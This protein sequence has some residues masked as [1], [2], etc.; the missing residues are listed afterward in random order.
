MKITYDIDVQESN[1][2]YIKVAEEAL[3]GLHEASIPGAFLVDL[4]P[5]LKFVPSWFPGAG[6][7]IKAAHCREVNKAMIENPFRYVKEQLVG[8]YYF[9]REISSLIE[10]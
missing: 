6:F 9:F 8:N 3:K 4:F 2:P 10:R 7:Q 5:M 1:D